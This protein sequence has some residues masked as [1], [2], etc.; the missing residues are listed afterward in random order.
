MGLELGD[1][2]VT[3]RAVHDRAASGMR[4]REQQRHDDPVREHRG[5]ACRHERSGQARQGDHAGH[6]ADDDEQLDDHDRGHAGCEQLAERVRGAQ[7]GPVAARG[8]QEE[9]DEDR[10]HADEPELLAEGRDDHVRI[11]IGDQIGSALAPALAEQPAGGQAEQALHDLARAADGGVVDLRIEGVDPGVETGRDVA[12]G[13]RGHEA[14]G[15]HEDQP[16]DDPAQ[17]AGGEV[18]HGHEQAEEQDRGAEVA[19]QHEHPDGHEPRGE[20]GREIPEARQM[21]GTD[22]GPGQ[23][24]DVAVRGQV[25]REEDRQGDLGDLAGLEGPPA[26]GDPD[27]CSVDLGAEPGQ[28]RQDQQQGGGHQRDVGH[29][30]KRPVVPEQQEHRGSGGHAHARP[31]QLAACGV[32]VHQ[33]VDPVDHRQAE[34]VEG[35]DDRQD[36]RIRVRGADPQDDMHEQGAA[37]QH[38]RGAQHM[39]A[40]L[41]EALRVHEEVGPDGQGER[42]QQQHE[43]GHAPA[44][45]DRLPRGGAECGDGGLGRHQPSPPSS[46]LLEDSG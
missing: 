17:A 7:R 1:L 16:Q 45:L 23:Q 33:Q 44:A 20:Q 43:L 29:L 6:A 28:Q 37:A 19:L 36:V 24:D 38:D 31:Q 46:A 35:H 26:D 8:Q 2:L 4:D 9:Q 27:P 30:A 15:G 39:P 34:A 5:A 42:E 13:L 41:G 3:G 10:G 12:E 40:V 22:L 25:A 21:Q 18:E 14:P 11:G 32:R